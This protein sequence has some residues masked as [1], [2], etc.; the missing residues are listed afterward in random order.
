VPAGRARAQRLVR[1]AVHGARIDH[2]QVAGIAGQQSALG[3]HVDQPRHATGAGMDPAHGAGLE[4]ETLAA[5][6]AEAVAQV[7]GGFGRI[8]RGQVEA[9]GDPLRQLPQFR[10]REDL[11][12]FRLPEQDHLQQLLGV[13]FQVG[14]QAH[15]FQRID[16]QVL[17]LV[18]DQHHPLA[19]GIGLQQEAV[20]RVDQRLAAAAAAPDVQPQL[21]ADRL[22]QL[23]RA[24]PWVQDQ[25]HPRVHGQ[26]FQQ[27]PA[28]RGLAGADLAGELHEAAAAALVDPE[29]QVRQ[30]VPVALAE[31]HEARVRGDRIRR[32]VQ[33]V[34]REV[35]AGGCLVGQGAA[36]GGGMAPACHKPAAPRGLRPA[37]AGVRRHT[38]GGRRSMPV[39]RR[40]PWP[41][42]SRASPGAPVAGCG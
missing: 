29:R 27:Q 8:Q 14:E 23:D 7:G 37:G 26:L 5:G 28:Q 39:S 36:A 41:R 33:A 4:G 42:R 18:D 6:D 19:V 16:R 35:H 10:A 20:E 25:R 17:G 11:A 40:C 15:L 13:G 3:D 24:L 32:L 21:L 2:G 12:Q 34:M 22:Q 31:E 30:R 1:G 9:R 38:G